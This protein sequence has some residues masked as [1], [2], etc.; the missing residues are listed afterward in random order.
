[1]KLTEQQQKHLRGLAHKL[2]PVV[3][4]GQHGLKETIFEEIDIALDVHELIKVKIAVG[5]RDMR[6]EIIAEILD[7]SKATLIQRVG[8]IATLF[9]RN[10]RKPRIVLSL[11]K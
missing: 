4:V 1:M 3:M 7:R 6:D 10:P 8:N 11:K 2:K 9:R 5:D